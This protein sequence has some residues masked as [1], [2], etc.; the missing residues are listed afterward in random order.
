MAIALTIIAMVVVA[1][2]IASVAL[3]VVTLVQNSVAKAQPER[4]LK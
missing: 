2:V 3:A 1:T 4:F